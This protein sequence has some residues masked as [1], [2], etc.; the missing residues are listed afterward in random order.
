[1]ALDCVRALTRNVIQR[2]RG[3]T[4]FEEGGR[5]QEAGGAKACD[6]HAT[7]MLRRPWQSWRRLRAF[8]KVKSEIRSCEAISTERCGGPARLPP[9]LA[10]SRGTCRR[11]PRCSPRNPPESLFLPC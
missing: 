8:F 9:P 2:L 1:M 5:S 7:A 10:Q 6:K 4:A 11:N 3:S